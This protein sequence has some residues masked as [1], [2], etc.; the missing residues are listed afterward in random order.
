[1]YFTKEQMKSLAIFAVGLLILIVSFFFDK[2]LHT[3]LGNFRTPLFDYLFTWVSYALSLI[4]V[5][6][7]MTSLFMWEEGKKDWIIPMWMSFV[8]ALVASFVLKLVVG[9]ERPMEYVMGIFTNIDTYSFPSTHAAVCFSLVPMLDRLYPTLKWFW[10]GF[11]V[12]VAFSRLYLGVHY[13][14]DVIAGGLIGFAIGLGM[15]FTKQKYSLF[16]ASR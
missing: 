14:S 12:V 15:L 10:V 8:I 5:L 3:L 6:L 2:S 4:F 1:M 9:R 7:I 13:L 16:G 11:A